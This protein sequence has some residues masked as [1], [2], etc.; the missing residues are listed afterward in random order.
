MVVENRTGNKV[1]ELARAELVSGKAVSSFENV[2]V[3]I[4]D[5]YIPGTL[6]ATHIYVVFISS[7]ADSP[8]VKNVK[9]SNGAF[10]GYADARRIGSVLTVDNIELIY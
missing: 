7:T 8:A 6:K 2:K 1:T 5:D 9:G 3:M 4:K 10:A